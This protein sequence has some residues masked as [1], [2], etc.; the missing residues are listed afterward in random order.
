MLK[1]KNLKKLCKKAK[2]IEGNTFDVTFEEI[3]SYIEQ[4]RFDEA[5]PY[6]EEILKSG[7]LDIRLVMYL[8]YAHFLKDG[9]NSFLEIFP[10]TIML[11]GE[12]WE[13]ISPEKGRD[14]H[15]EI[16]LIW[17]F[18]SIK[19]RLIWSERLFHKKQ[20]DEFWIK[21]IEPLQKLE[22]TEV[23]ELTTEIY[24]FITEKWEKSAVS[25]HILYV[26]KW[27]DDLSRVESI[28]VN[29]EIS[30]TPQETEITP[31]KAYLVPEVNLEKVL[32]SSE[33]M[34]TLHQKIQTF[35]LLIKNK[36]FSKAAFVADDIKNVINTFN[37]IHFF[38]KLFS[39]HFALL[40]KHIDT[41]SQ[42]WESK[43]TLKWKALEQLYHADIKEFINL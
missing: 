39:V 10:L 33:K 16:A 43:D 30:E 9:V 19:K 12:Y 28:K 13:K 31:P 1:I 3:V 11:L 36:E 6:I 24:Q 5:L 38:P 25:Q 35:E 7:C 29:N 34:K 17:F 20:P 37:P 21:N 18:S 4:E 14:K 2:C 8:F 22:L 41:I 23:K 32:L 27:L 26:S 40:S 42:H 15:V